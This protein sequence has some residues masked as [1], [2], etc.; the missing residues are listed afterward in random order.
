MAEIAFF[1]VWVKMR[2]TG[3]VATET[4]ENKLR[5]Y[6]TATN[7]KLIKKWHKTDHGPAERVSLDEHWSIMVQTG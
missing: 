2:E 4:L 7:R 3:L 6:Q 1:G 5:L